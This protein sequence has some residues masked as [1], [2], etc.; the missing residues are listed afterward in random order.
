MSR[1]TNETFSEEQAARRR[2]EVLRKA[3]R[4]LAA[5]CAALAMSRL[6]RV[7]RGGAAPAAHPPPESYP[8]AVQT[9]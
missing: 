8:R 3:F 6:D 7:P 9:R 2:D 1:E 4:R 5:I